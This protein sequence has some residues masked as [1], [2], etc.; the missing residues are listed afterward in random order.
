MPCEGGGNPTFNFEGSNPW[1]WKIQ[2]VGT[3]SPVDELFV[4]GNLGTKTDDNFWIV[5]EGVPFYG[6]Q[7]VETNTILSGY[8]TNMVTL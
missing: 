7:I 1:Y 5:Q 3:I 4:N 8:Y 6:E 2:P